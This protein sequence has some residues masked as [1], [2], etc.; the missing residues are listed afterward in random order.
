MNNELDRMRKVAVIACFKGGTEENFE[1]FSHE[2]WSSER[3]PK[4]GDHEYKQ[5][6]GYMIG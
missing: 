2:S 4:A 3:E 5:G 1:N 6:L